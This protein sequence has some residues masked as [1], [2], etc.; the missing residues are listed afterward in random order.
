MLGQEHELALEDDRTIPTRPGEAVRSAP[1]ERAPRA[2]LFDLDGVITDTA[3]VHARAWKALF[4]EF[5]QVLADECGPAFRE[6][7]IGDD[8]LSYVDGRRRYDGV[9]SFLASRAIDLPAGTPEDSP[10]ERTIAGLGNRKDGYFLRSLARDGVRAFDDAVALLG[11]AAP[12]A[13]HSPSCRPA[14]TA[15][16]F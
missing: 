9:A 8:Y 1:V 14:G 3:A 6:F 15:T 11:A 2:L 12:Q 13:S 7:D 4:D 16:P 10:D 5:L